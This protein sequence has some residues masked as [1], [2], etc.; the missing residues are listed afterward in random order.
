MLDEAIFHVGMPKTGTTSIQNAMFDYDD[1]QVFYARLGEINHSRFICTA[2]QTNFT[3]YHYWRKRGAPVEEIKKRRR[4]FKRLIAEQMES[5]EGG[6]IILSGE[7]MGMM[8]PDGVQALTGF[9]LKRARKIRGLCYVREPADYAS[10]VFQQMCKAGLAHIPDKLNP[11]YRYRLEKFEEAFGKGN[12]VVRD[13]RRTELKDGCVV[14][15]FCSVLGID[16]LQP[17]ESRENESMS[18]GALKALFRFNKTNPVSLGDNLTYA[19]RARFIRLLM[20][21]MPLKEFGRIDKSL[22]S[23]LADYSEAQY[24]EEN[25]GVAAKDERQPQSASK[26][27]LDSWLNEIDQDIDEKVGDLINEITP[28]NHFKSFDE[29]LNRLYYYSLIETAKTLRK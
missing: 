23:E 26:S 25:F 9:T 4:Q 17:G 1:G 27:D 10:S 8:D 7:D 12:L 11:R 19:A 20:Q 16:R 5:R 22:F 28:R 3:A 14:A 18:A 13:F 21:H 2:F 29:K 24:L 6:T 15:D